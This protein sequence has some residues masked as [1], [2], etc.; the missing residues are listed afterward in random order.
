MSRFLLVTLLGWL[1]KRSAASQYEPYNVWNMDESGLFFPM[2]PNRSYYSA[3]EF[4]LEIRGTEFGKCKDRVTIV[5]PCN[6]DGS[7]R[8]TTSY[9]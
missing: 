8:T 4:R 9:I 5:S 1:G 6:A 7:Q 3:S 2:G